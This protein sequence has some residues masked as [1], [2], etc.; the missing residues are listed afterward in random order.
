MVNN[1]TRVRSIMELLLPRVVSEASSGLAFLYQ[2]TEH[3]VSNVANG[4][5]ISGNIIDFKLS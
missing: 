5:S 1:E 2:L 4:I 3:M